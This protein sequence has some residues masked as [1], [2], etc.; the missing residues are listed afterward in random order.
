MDQ[1][2]G[3]NLFERKIRKVGQSTI[4]PSLESNF[5]FSF[6]YPTFIIPPPPPSGFFESSLNL[7]QRMHTAEMRNIQMIIAA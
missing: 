7:F 4:Q 1:K 3:E 2:N 6:Q 5:P